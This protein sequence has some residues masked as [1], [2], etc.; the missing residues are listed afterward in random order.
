MK[1]GYRKKRRRLGGRLRGKNVWD[2]RNVPLRGS[3]QR[4]KEA[5]QPALAIKLTRPLV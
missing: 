2:S 3:Y 5:R 1:G 4:P